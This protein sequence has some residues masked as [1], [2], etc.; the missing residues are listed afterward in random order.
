MFSQSD[1]DI[2]GCAV[3][4]QASWREEN[5]PRTDNDPPLTPQQ[6]TGGD[7]GFCIIL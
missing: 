7:V 1:K 5:S 4:A 2:K 6:H 3:E